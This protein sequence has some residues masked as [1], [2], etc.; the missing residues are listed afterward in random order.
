MTRPGKRSPSQEP[1]RQIVPSSTDYFLA[2]RLVGFRRWRERD[3]PLAMELWGDPEVTAY[4]GGPFTEERVRS[5]LAHE[6][7]QEQE[8]GVQY[9]PFF[10]LGGNRHA[11]CAGL[12]PYRVEERIYEFGIHLRSAYWGRGLAEEAARLVIDYGFVTLGAAALFAGHH[13]QNEASRRLL[14]KLGFVHTHEELYPPTG[15]LHP[16]Y[17][18]RQT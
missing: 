11:G 12:R 17:I 16:S 9:W 8:F 6:I 1:S 7:A 18:L 10:L 4:I 3:L 13:P 5:R 14:L 2:S 15:L